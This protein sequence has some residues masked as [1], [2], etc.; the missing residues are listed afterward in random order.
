MRKEYR[1]Y[2]RCYNYWHDKAILHRN[3]RRTTR[4]KLHKLVKFSP[5][6]YN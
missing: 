3:L 5:S 6:D 1:E 4:H 2:N